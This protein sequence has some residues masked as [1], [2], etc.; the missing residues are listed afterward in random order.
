MALRVIFHCAD[1]VEQQSVYIRVI[2]KHL[3][4][5]LP[6]P[7]LHGLFGHPNPIHESDCLPCCETLRF[8]FHASPEL[9]HENE[10]YDS[11]Y[12]PFPSVYF[13][14]EFKSILNESSKTDSYVSETI[15]LP[16]QYKMA[17]SLK[18]VIVNA[19]VKVSQENPALNVEGQDSFEVARNAFIQ[20]L[21]HELFPE[22]T[23]AVVIPTAAKD[24]VDELTEQVK[25]LKIEAPKEKKPRKPRAKKEEVPMNM[26]KMDATLSKQ[27]TAIAKEMKVKADKKDVLAYLN[28]MSSEDYN[29]KKFDEHV[30]NFLKKPEENKE[31]KKPVELVG[32][33]LVWTE[34]E[35]EEYYVDPE[36]K[37]VFVG[38]GEW[39]DGK[40]AAWEPVGYMGMAKFADMVLED[41]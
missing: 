30:R 34:F 13:D 16:Q 5:P 20:A 26:A 17:S 25:N 40:P 8:P 37:R 9:R 10:C 24:P 38:V 6:L 12:T 15:R 1:S 28:A 39:T 23:T 4:V 33:E 36:S 41:D 14:N 2:V 3:Q 7:V 31:E 18:Q 32:V 27:L 22:D 19:I 21:L 11:F 29:A 35:G